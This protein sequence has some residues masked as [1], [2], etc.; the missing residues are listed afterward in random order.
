[1]SCCPPLA[2][3]RLIG[4]AYTDKNLV[5]SLER[6]KLPPRMASRDLEIHLKGIVKVIEALLDPDIFV[7]VGDRRRPSAEERIRASTIVADRLTGAVANPIIRNAQ[8]KRQ[9]HVIETYL[10]KRGYKRKPHPRGSPLTAMPPGTFTFHHSLATG[11]DA[12]RVN[13]SVDAM[14]QPHVLRRRSTARHGRGKIG[15]RFHK[16]E[17][18]AE[19]GSQEYQPTEGDLRRRRLLRR[20]SC[21]AISTPATWATRRR[22]ASIGSGNIGSTT[23]SNWASNDRRT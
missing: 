8:E 6:K 16:Y 2:V 7:W 3:D 1:M 11:S 15:R 21:A 18:A 10:R 12:H 22:T 5:K 4:L 9:L 14:I 19:R 13:V 20:V 23:L 17:Q